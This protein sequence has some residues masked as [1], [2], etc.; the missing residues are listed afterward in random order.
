M[1]Q[2]RL[3]RRL[4]AHLD[5]DTEVFAEPRPASAGLGNWL[6]SL[7]SFEGSP[8]LIFLSESS[9]YSFWLP[10]T[11]APLE[12]VF[13]GGLVGVLNMEG[14]GD[15]EILRIIGEALPLDLSLSVERRFSS[16]LGQLNAQYR[17]HL[18]R[19]GGLSSASLA[20]AISRVN[21]IPLKR[22]EWSTPAEILR[23]VLSLTC[24]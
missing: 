16:Y 5:F 15:L 4:V 8:G 11:G 22:L 1:M 2:L 6:V 24:Q 9:L 23:E 20:A 21:R 12:Q 10:E 14:F 19:E 7:A 13:L 17:F 3:T 18:K